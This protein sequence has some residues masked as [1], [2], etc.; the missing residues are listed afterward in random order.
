MSD[1]IDRHETPHIVFGANAGKP[2]ERLAVQYR[3]PS[4]LRA[5]QR[6]ARSH[7]K[8]QIRQIAKSI[9]TFGFVN[10]VLIDASGCI[11]AG[12][13]RVQAA[14]L[15]GLTEIPTVELARMSDAQRRAYAIADNR[16]AELGG[17]EKDLLKLELGELSIEFPDLDLT[18][19]GFESAELDLIILGDAQVETP[20]ELKSDGISEVSGSPVTR[21]GD[22]WLLESHR[23]LCGD[24]RHAESYRRL[25]AD[26][27]ARLVVTD[28][29]YNVPIDG[30]ARG[31]GQHHHGDFVM[32]S[33]EMTEGEFTAFLTTIFQHLINVSVPGAVHYTFMDWRHLHEVLSAGRGNYQELLNLCVWAKNNGG[34]GSFYRSEHELVLVWQVAG[35]SHL[36]NVQLG[37]YGRT[38]TNVW[39]YT[40]VNSFGPERTEMLA[41]HPTPKP[42]TLLADAILDASNRGDLVLDPFVGSGS[43][44]IAANN[45]GRIGF[46]ME[47]DPGY[48]DVALRRFERLTGIEARHAVSG[49]SFM[50]EAQLRIQ[51]NQSAEQINSVSETAASAGE[52]A[53]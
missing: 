6:N 12:H 29:P 46:G 25:M 8:R 1:G 18:V 35:G 9:E 30:H 3:S 28:P 37:K 16:L 33:G 17:W 53:S 19:T 44:I 5:Q 4:S 40:G 47:L 39:R 21:V 42:V 24:A 14:R 13:G 7:T 10:P 32:A 23:L 31:L 11:V 52:Q 26:Q 50:Q 27:R 2:V 34:M 43:T 15:I 41:S 48:V 38:R 20:T 36:N 49:L 51:K 22:L 45:V